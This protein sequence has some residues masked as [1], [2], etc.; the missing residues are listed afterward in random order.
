MLLVQVCYYVVAIALL[1]AFLAL[2]S[3][4]PLKFRDARTAVV[5]WVVLVV[6]M[7]LGVMN[8]NM[9]GSSPTEVEILMSFCLAPL[10]LT[11]YITKAMQLWFVHEWSEAKAAKHKHE[12]ALF[13]HKYRFLLTFDFFMYAM[14]FTLV[15]TL[16]PA[17]YA[18][19]GRP[20]FS[21]A[22]GDNMYS[23]VRCSWWEIPEKYTVKKSDS[24]LCN[25][26]YYNVGLPVSF[27]ELLA[28]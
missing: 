16:I 10:V 6:N 5:L 20:T 7:T 19:L 26:V 14:L 8:R 15:V 24:L 22:P 4:Q 2:R 3:K 27:G 11:Y 9:A 12:K 28:V 18:L 13:F 21:D 17:L 25:C 23:N 1:A